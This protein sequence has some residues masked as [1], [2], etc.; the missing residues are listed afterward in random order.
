MAAVALA[1][2]AH[3]ARNPRNL[4]HVIMVVIGLAA[5]EGLARASQE[6]SLARLAAWDKQR[7][8]REQR[9]AKH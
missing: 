9:A 1:A 2:A 7:S 5:V 3:A 6:R 8:L 4:Q